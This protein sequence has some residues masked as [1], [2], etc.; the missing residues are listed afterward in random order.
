[1]CYYVNVETTEREAD[2]QPE[3]AS[4]GGPRV[5]QAWWLATKRRRAEWQELSAAGLASFSGRPR[6]NFESAQP[7]DPVLLYVATPDKAIRA[8]GVITHAAGSRPPAE[9]ADGDTPPAP[10]GNG[11]GRDLH[12]EVQFAFEVPNP[13]GWHDILATEALEAAEPVRLRSSGTLFYLTPA[14]YRTLEALIVARNPEL[15]P[16]FA[17][18]D[19]GLLPRLPLEVD[20]S[21]GGGGAGLRVRETAP[22]YAVP[23]PS[24]PPP[25]PPPLPAVHTVEQL[26]ALTLLP[27]AVLEEMA[28]VLDEAGQIILSG[29]PG[30]GK[31]WVARGLAALVAGDPARVE[32]VQFHPATTYEDFIEGLK[33]RVDAWG[34]VTYAVLP[35]LFLRLCARARNDPDAIYVLIIDEINRAPL[36]RVFGELL[37]ALEY[38]GPSGAVELTTGGAGGPPQRFYVPDNVRIIGTMNSADRSIALVDYALRRRF[39][40]LE[41]E[42]DPQVLDTW[43]AAHGVDATARAVILD[44]FRRLNTRLSE[45]LDPD[46][47]LGHTYFMRSPMTAAGLDRLWR[48]A[49]RPLLAEYFVPPTGE[50]EEYTELVARAARELESNEA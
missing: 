28:E 30:T 11:A 22:P 37:Y 21:P 36:S 47:R 8:V 42:P 3:A 18:L 10:S 41:L 23:E 2:E 39:R 9:P 5:R 50:I 32:V 40:F 12:I 20:H 4:D 44:L 33:P 31:T 6:P 45:A 13:L 48:T 26:A 17:A 24:V 14:E 43:L 15:A 34:H 29:P 38:R 27:P 35:G 19:S 7:G 46:H 25:A 1:L 49:I 16:A